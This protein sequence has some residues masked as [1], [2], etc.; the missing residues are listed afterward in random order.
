MQRRLLA[1]VL[2]CPAIIGGVNAA[3]LGD[4]VSVVCPVCD[5]AFETMTA[6]P[7]DARGGTD[8]DFFART[9]G[10]QPICQLITTCPR[11]YYS[12]Y[13]DDFQTA[14]RVD[15]AL[16][17]KILKEPRLHPATAISEGMKQTDIPA[18]TRY[19]LAAKVYSW[20]AASPEAQ[21]WLHLRW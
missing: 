19:A 20:R 13:I 8:R 3:A 2:A 21:A 9:L 16:R 14:G 11:C 5:N 4:P 17:N 6:E 15:R 1:M 12:G 7:G 18:T 10:S